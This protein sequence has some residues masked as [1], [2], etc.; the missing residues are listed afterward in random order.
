VVSGGR[1]GRGV[2]LSA[3]RTQGRSFAGSPEVK[4]GFSVLL[5]TADQALRL[6]VTEQLGRFGAGPVHI[7]ETAEKV[8]RKAH[9]LGACDLALVDLQWPGGTRLDLIGWLRARGWPSVVAISCGPAVDAAV[10]A[11]G[12]GTRAFLQH[13]PDLRPNLAER[14]SAVARSRFTRSE[15]SVIRLVAD[16]RSNREIGRALHMTENMVKAELVRLGRRFN[17][18]CRAHI[19]AE[20]LR[21]GVVT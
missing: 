19:V 12:S 10:A 7:A 6:R 16:G 8:L 17:V 13:L 3:G 21:E 20:A 11:L 1:F 2:T 18:S 5:A 14:R 4:S 15:V 9:E